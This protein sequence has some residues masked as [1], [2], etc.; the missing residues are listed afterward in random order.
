MIA[1]CHGI[2]SLVEQYEIY[3]AVELER[4][5]STHVHPLVNGYPD[6][7]PLIGRMA[8]KYKFRYQVATANPLIP[9]PSRLTSHL[10][11]ANMKIIT[12]ATSVSGDTNQE[13]LTIRADKIVAKSLEIY[14]F[15][16][17]CGV[18]VESD[19]YPHSKGN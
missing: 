16:V 12:D 4:F 5:C 13:W 9:L 17:T 15:E 2:V 7:G 18:Q 1:K 6:A 10:G 14:Y 19:L 3:V 8:R 11:T